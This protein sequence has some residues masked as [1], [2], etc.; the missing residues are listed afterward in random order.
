MGKI[1]SLAEKSGSALHWSPEEMLEKAL[2]DVRG[3]QR[4]ANKAI[5]VFLD[6]TEGRYHIGYNQSGMRLSELV[7]LLEVVQ[8]DA[9]RDIGY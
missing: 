9:I 5:V 6:D 4:K 3:G 8:A 2:D 7:A 1:V